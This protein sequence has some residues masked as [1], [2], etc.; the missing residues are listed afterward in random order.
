MAA[1]VTLTIADDGEVDGKPK[2]DVTLRAEPPFP[3]DASG[4][5]E[6]DNMTHAQAVAYGIVLG[7]SD[8]AGRS[9]MFTQEGHTI[10]E[11]RP[12]E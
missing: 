9:R 3:L 11:L 8:D 4:A 1:V 6:I 7:M 5:P 10:T 12:H 2:V